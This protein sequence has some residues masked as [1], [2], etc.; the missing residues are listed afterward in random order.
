M[1]LKAD[2]GGRSGGFP[3]ESKV[4]YARN[5]PGVLLEDTVNSTSSDYAHGSNCARIVVHIDRF[6]FVASSA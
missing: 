6:R 3:R 4:G 1:R 5:K 2:R